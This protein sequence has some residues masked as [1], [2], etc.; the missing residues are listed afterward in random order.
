M[1]IAA[2]VQRLL[3]RARSERGVI[4]VE[5]AFALPAILVTAFAVFEVAYVV[6]VIEMGQNAVSESLTQFRKLGQLPAS[7]ETDIR[8][9]IG[10]WSH[11]LLEPRD[12]TL[13]RVDRY[14][15]LA[16]YGKAAGQGAGGNTGNNDNQDEEE[17]SRY[18]CWHIV[19]GIKKSF[20]T[21]VM[22]MLPAKLNSFT[23]RYERIVTY[24]PDPAQDDGREGS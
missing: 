24:L 4:S 15:S 6:L 7:V 22:R 17:E 18:P 23:Y 1:P 13:V 21:P 12:V 14:D 19:V 3:S 5:A 10:Y 2:L 9:S 8:Q 20:I 16:D 11:G